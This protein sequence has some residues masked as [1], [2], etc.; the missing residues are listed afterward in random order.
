MQYDDERPLSVKMV[1]MVLA[2]WVPRNFP[3]HF[4]NVQAL[5]PGDVDE[6]LRP[7]TFLDLH[8]TTQGRRKITMHDEF[9]MQ[10]P[11]LPHAPPSK[12]RL[13]FRE[14][15]TALLDE[16]STQRRRRC[17]WLCGAHY[18]ASEFF[19]RCFKGGQVFTSLA[20]NALLN[21]APWVLTCAEV[22]T[23]LLVYFLSVHDALFVRRQLKM[24]R[25]QFSDSTEDIVCV[26]LL[27]GLG[28]LVAYSMRM[29]FL[30]HPSY[31]IS[32]LIVAALHVPYLSIKLGAVAQ[33]GKNSPA[34][35]LCSL[36]M[37]FTLA[38]VT[39]AQS[40]ITWARRR[41]R[42]GLNEVG[43]H[44]GSTAVAE[45]A[46]AL[47][48]D[49]P[50]FD[51][52]DHT[53]HVTQHHILTVDCSF[54]SELGALR[55]DHQ[56]C[57]H[58]TEN[59]PTHGSDDV[60]RDRTGNLRA[61]IV[62]IHG[63]GGGVHSWRHIAQPL[64]DSVGVKVIAFD[65]PG[66]GLSERP[67]AGKF[68]HAVN[69]EDG[70]EYGMFHTNPYS[71]PFQAILAAKI[72]DQMH[73]SRVIFMGV[74]DGALIAFLAARYSDCSDSVDEVPTKGVEAKEREEDGSSN[75]SDTNSS[76]AYNKNFGAVLLHPDLSGRCGPDYVGALGRSN[77]SRTALQ[78]LLA[79]EIGDVG[80]PR[81]WST[82]TPPSHVVRLYR[83][84]LCARSG[85]ERALVEVCI[86]NSRCMDRV[87]TESPSSGQ[88]HSTG[89]VLVI[90]GDGEAGPS[91]LPSS[92]ARVAV[93]PNCVCLAHEERPLEVVRIAGQF[94]KQVLYST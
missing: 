91:R 23:C 86:V 70:M 50:N 88:S 19:I 22:L 48:L 25:F 11:L 38:H 34:I 37:F 7:N 62:L 64:A 24:Y 93:L 27:R 31:L 15:L 21:A 81:A 13:R 63:Y 8:I 61:G 39:A 44:C 51:P 65:R 43:I 73:L 1:Y 32:S 10:D 16:Y 89:S 57:V 30:Y 36:Q 55:N 92:C 67:D 9:R 74:G 72:A 20:A 40:A 90:H 71:I 35:V 3:I 17:S 58:C 59:V 5:A 75:G 42:L 80:N 28:V 68:C 87:V 85:W 46:H 78:H 6:T 52:G 45:S 79:R 47:P 60:S 84:M 14:S 56:L 83:R 82:G 53:Y 41:C 66:F 76:N 2:F 29:R 33:Q 77:I 54:G 69:N 12:G 26:A 49:W 18:N 94:S 4:K